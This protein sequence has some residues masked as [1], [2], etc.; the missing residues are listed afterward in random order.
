MKTL[1]LVRHGKAAPR[2]KKE[3]DMQRKLSKIGRQE[4]HALSVRLQKHDM[5]PDAI[6]SSPARRA[7][8]TAQVFAET[9]G[10]DPARIV[11]KEELYQKESDGIEDVVLSLDD[12]YSAV[13]LVGHAPALS[14]FTG[15]F[16]HAPGSEFPTSSVVGLKLPIAS[17]R[18]FSPHD[19]KLFLYDFPVRVASKAEKH[20][21]EIVEKEMVASVS[22]ILDQIDGKRAKQMHHII[23]NTS[24]RFAQELLN[25][26]QAREFEE[27]AAEAALT[28]EADLSAKIAAAQRKK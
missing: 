10:S 24:K 3:P 26:L 19:A 1:Y 15:E 28:A 20:A 12:A 4:A 22:G 21:H 5:L 16:L 13:M 18:D 11:S 9:F 27:T 14:A 2:R 8:E 6:L 23:A 17:W 7:I 25:V